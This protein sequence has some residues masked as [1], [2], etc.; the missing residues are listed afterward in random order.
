MALE[1]TVQRVHDL[2]S[3]L[4]LLRDELDWPIQSSHTLDDTT[5]E[6][7]AD[8]LSLNESA[9]RQLKDGVVRQL[10][11]FAE[12]QPWGIFFVEFANGQVY[13][14]ALRQVLR[15]LVHKRRCASNLPAWRH[16]NLLFLCTPKNQGR[17]TF[18]HFRGQEVRRALLSTFG[19]EQGDKHIRTLCE[20]NLSALRM[21]SDGG[22]DTDGWAT[23]WRTAWDVE[24][25]SEHFFEDYR[26]V[27]EQFE[28]PVKKVLKD[29][30]RLFTQTLFN[31]LM[32]CAFLQKKGWLNRDRC[33]LRTLWENACNNNSY[34]RISSR[35]NFYSDYLDPLFFEAMNTP[36]HKRRTNIT[37]RLGDIPFLN[38]GLFERNFSFD[39]PNAITIPNDAFAAIFDLFDH[40]NFTVTES[41]PLNINVA[42]DPEM[43]GRVFE[44]L[45]TGR[46]ETGSYFTPRAVVAF[47]CR[48]AIK[49]YLSSFMKAGKKSIPEEIIAFV[50]ENDPFRLSEPETMLEAIKHIKVCDP[51]CGSGAYLLGMMQELLRLRE[52]LFASK[53]KDH[54]KIYDRKLEIIR[55]NLYGVDKDQFAVNIA[56]LRLW[57]SLVVDDGRDPLNDPTVDVS[58]PNLKYKIQACDSLTAPNPDPA[59]FPLQSEVYSNDAARLESIY[60]EYFLPIHTN[61]KRE[62]AEIEKDIKK[63][64]NEISKLFGYEA[65]KD[66]IDWRVVFAPVFAPQNQ[67]SS[68]FVKHGGFDIVIANPPY[69]RADPLFKHLSDDEIA[70]QKAIAQWKDYRAVLLNNGI[71]QTLYEKWDLYLPFLERAY[72]LMCNG[73]SMMFIVSDAYN[74]AKYARRSHEFFLRNTRIGRID[75]CSDIP[76]FKAG[77]N[78]TIVHFSKSE[79][80]ANHQPLRVRRWG[81][82]RDDFERNVEVLPT[83]PQAEF[84]KTIFRQDAQNVEEFS[85]GYVSLSKICFIS[86]G[87]VINADERG[88]QGAFKADD[89][90]SGSKDAIHPKQ[91]IF[92][93]D[94]LKWYIRN[95]RFLEWGTKRAPAQFRRPTFPQLYAAKEKLIAVRTPGAE[96]KVFYDNN[97]L[98][99]DASS[100]GFVPW[101]LLKG[102][103]NK[104]ITKT[105]K[106]RRQDSFGDREEREKISKQFHIKYVLAVLNSKLA[107]K[108]LASRRRSKRH[109]YPDDWKSLPIPP[110]QMEK[111]M[112]LV[113]LVNDILAEFTE[114][115]H[116]LPPSSA[117][118]VA[119]LEQDIDE[120]IAALYSNGAVDNSTKS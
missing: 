18:A 3:L 33:Y 43:L 8:E 34:H 111:Q 52:N 46:H 81:E 45:V 88:C 21:P 79:P 39:Q 10:R 116:S 47:M 54:T 99:F 103:V 94:I 14:T 73:G 77:V 64:Q 12:N 17:F 92:G 107:Q 67:H 1:E 63:T 84:S 61:G 62:K 59:C 48:E 57:L 83:A 104:S 38:G 90:F 69:V 58:L 100:I 37:K 115:G 44:E 98:H 70:R 36:I 5:F 93:K 32:F 22:A 71:Y 7:K 108:W 60:D 9:T 27:F 28:V 80:D 66:E 96:P 2:N 95:L 114:H 24:K 78:N 25:V 6:W 91:F 42:V 102:V 97:Y 87:M 82:K 86:V 53:V 26:Q 41:T 55:R 110:V 31:R 112:D 29:D 19:W 56:M 109:I 106:Y 85:Q 13:H 74:A 30:A 15:G 11:P 105:V 49:D 4:N 51:A 16:E 35:H 118:R 50:D 101:Y 72:Q 119:K 68:Q 120:R 117:K 76:L 23:Q 89:L 20:F 113:K 75:F 65:Q 40:Y